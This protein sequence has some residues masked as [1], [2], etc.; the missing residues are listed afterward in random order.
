LVRE[1]IEQ[2]RQ[3][4]HLFFETAH[5]RRDGTIIPTELSSRIIT[6]AGKPAVLSIARDITERKQA[7]VRA[8]HLKSVLLAIRG[9]NQLITHEHDRNRLIQGVCDELIETRG[10]DNVWVALRDESG[11]VVATAEAGLGDRFLSLVEQLERGEPPH[12]MRTALTQADVLLIDDPVATCTGCTLSTGYSGRKAMAVRL[13]HGGKVYGLMTVSLPGDY[14][15]D[16]EE[17]TLF[18]EVA[19]DIA[20]ALYDIELEEKRKQ[21]EAAVRESEERFRQVVETMKVGMGAVD[22]NSVLTYVNEYLSKMLGYSVDEMIGRSTLDFYYDEESRKAQAEIFAK[23]RAGMRD[24]TPYE[25][26]WRRKDGQK[27]YAIVSPTPL[28]DAAGRYTGS[29]AI[30]TDITERRLAEEALKDSEEQFRNLAEQSP[31]MIYINVEGRIV[32]ANKK[33]AELTGYTREE[34]FAPDFNFMSLIAPESIDLVKGIYGRHMRGEEVAPYEYTLITKEGKKLQA[35]N[36]TKLILYGGKQALL[37]VVTDITD[38]KQAEDA[39]QHS[40][41]QMREMLVTTI[42]ALASMVEMK[43][44]YTAGHQPRVTRLACAIA[45]EMGLSEEQIEG[46]R[47]AGSVHDIGKTVVPAE[48][49]NKPGPLTEMQFEMVKMHPRAGHDILKK[50]TFPWP[51]A[52]IVLQHHEL[53]DGSGYPQGLSGEEIMLEA[54]ILTVANVVEAM[55]SHRPYRAAY[56]IKEALEE[57]SK[58]RGVL[59][60]P[61]VVD[62]CLML[63]ERGFSYS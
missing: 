8:E 63:F 30:H 3:V 24:P 19:E 15:A 6:Y 28:F 47:M 38:R 4:G 33:G 54:R 42:D 27:V 2:L 51:V 58:N 40:Y 49:L 20:F 45:G 32:Y 52:Q 26:I 14:V 44:Q 55:I 48:I 53:M 62:A 36:A 43:D 1:R 9:I 61:A 22:E 18:K 46:I 31:N 59:Y 12:C 29:F 10:Y 5:V 25:V 35:I 39:L 13:K 11:T 50:I 16:E 7:E 41:R 60:D 17:L 34:F 23:R 21:A 56:E 57:I 37:G